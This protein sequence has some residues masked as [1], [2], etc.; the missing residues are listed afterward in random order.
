[1]GQAKQRGSYA[2]RK[3]FALVQEKADYEHYVS[4]MQD[5]KLR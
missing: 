4:H 2:Q 5:D 3:S 1:M